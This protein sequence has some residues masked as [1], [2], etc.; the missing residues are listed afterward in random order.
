MTPPRSPDGV[1]RNPGQAVTDSPPFPECPPL[2][3]SAG[4]PSGLRE[5]A[6]SIGVALVGY[7]YAGRTFHAPLIRSTPGVE[8]G[9]VVTSRP[10]NVRAD[11][12]ACRSVADVREILQDPAIE[13][14][15]IAT[16]NAT[17]AP[18]AELALRAGKHVVVDKPLTLSL[19]DARRLAALAAEHGRLLSV[20]QNRRWD[21]DFLALQAVIAEGGVGTVTHLE[22]RFD[23]FR[24]EVRERWREGA[25]GGGIWFDLGPHLVDQALVLFG[26]PERVGG[27]MARRRPGAEA[28]DWCQVQ[29]DY[30]HL[31]VTLSAS[32]LVGGGIPRFAV[33]GRGGS[34]VSHGLDVQED[35]L[36]A[37]MR[38]GAEGWGR[39]LRPALRYRDG[40]TEECPIPAGDYP[41]YYHAVGHAIRGRGP[42]PV[43]PAEAVATMA[44]LE[45]AVESARARRIL[46]LPLSEAERGAFDAARPP[47]LPAA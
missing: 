12:P 8:L 34:W 37:G 28:D 26:L 43:A 46:P 11:I 9:V 20:F 33:H 45:T 15:V 22:S 31:Q 42:N 40:A 29:L 44:V 5:S 10:A 23:R 47:R 39:D 2:P 21:G 24:P 3:D 6:A 14:V 13:L 25:A 30:G 17:H 16:P 41:R 18:L 35:Q 19:A 1:Q 32:M 38:P 4:A 7:G 36:R 27:A